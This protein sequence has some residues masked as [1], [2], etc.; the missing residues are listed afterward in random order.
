MAEWKNQGPDPELSDEEMHHLRDLFFRDVVPKLVRLHARTGIVNCEFAGEEY[1]N[2]Q[3]R[4]RSRGS[5]F[6]VVEFEYD[7]EG[8]AMD[9]DL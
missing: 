4:F 9:L 1:R 6:E 3:I 2:W 7:E 8:T 5:D